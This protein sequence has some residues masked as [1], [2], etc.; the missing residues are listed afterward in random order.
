MEYQLHSYIPPILLYPPLS[1]PFHTSLL[2]NSI[3]QAYQLALQLKNPIERER[4]GLIVIK[5]YNC[6][7]DCNTKSHKI[8]KDVKTNLNI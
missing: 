5:Y 3:T 1:F 7:T 8:V 4:E 2:N 6:V